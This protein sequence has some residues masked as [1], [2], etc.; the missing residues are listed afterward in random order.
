MA[1]LMPS[2][3]P[4]PVQTLADKKIELIRL[5][6]DVKYTRGQMS[7]AIAACTDTQKLKKFRDLTVEEI[8]RITA[9]V[10]KEEGLL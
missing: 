7:I 9:Y 8:D 2:S 5:F 4:A 1:L 3:S 6:A 10:K